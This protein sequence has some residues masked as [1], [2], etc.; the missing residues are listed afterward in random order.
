M[1]KSAFKHLLLLAGALFLSMSVMV[2]CSDD[3]D[4]VD[5][6]LVEDGIYVAGAA[7]GFDE[8]RFEAMMQPGREEGDE[9]A[10]LLRDGMYET[11]LYLTAGSF[12]IVQVAGVEQTSYGWDA[13]G[14]QTM[15]LDGSGDDILGE[16]IHGG[17]QAGGND[18]SVPQTGFYH[19][20]MD[21]QTGTVYFTKIDFFGA[22]GDATDSGW[23]NQYQMDPVTV[24]QEEASWEAAGVTLRERGGIKFRY[25]DGWK[26][27]AEGFIIF[28]NIGIGENGDDFMMGGGTFPYPEDG[29]GEYTI[30]LNWSLTEGWSF[31]Y[32]RTGDVD[33]LPE[34][35]DSLYMIGDG[36]GGWGWEEINL[37]MV[38]VHSKPHLFWKIVWMEA[39][40]SFKFA[41]ARE[42][43][44]DFGVSGDGDDGIFDIGGDN[45]PVPGT[46]GYYM[47]VVNLH[48]DYNQIAVVDPTVYLIGDAID[49]WDTAFAAGLFDV[50]NANEVIVFDGAVFETNAIRM[51]AWF[52]AVEGWFTDWWQSEFM[53]LDG[54]I[55]FRGTGG[56]Q[57]RVAVSAGN[58]R[59]ELN[60]KE[61]TGSI[62]Q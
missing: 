26:I 57:D 4:D 30:T 61:N 16:V 11:F 54:E 2:S 56:D 60:F 59:I 5:P 15:T 9:F 10:S 19:I 43:A 21:H 44:G 14:A 1:K 35:P 12:N 46:A 50:D 18:F 58:A 7:T 62:T 37:P 45:A 41:P 29:E 52:D 42:W 40:G 28:A 31:E 34:F 55:A 27:E 33:P 48:E 23:A 3:E 32:D 13:D 22:I 20:V 24:A 47:V 6:I 36:V 51:Y 17:Y 39:E 49:S 38:P 53:I 25:N 8:L